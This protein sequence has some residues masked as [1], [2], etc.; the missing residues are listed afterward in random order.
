[1]TSFAP[2]VQLVDLVDFGALSG[3][4][5]A[6]ES[7]GGIAAGGA[8]VRGRASL[9][10][11]G[12]DRLPEVLEILLLGLELVELGVGVAVNPVDGLGDGLVD[13]LLIL[14]ADDGLELLVVEH[15]AQAVGEVLELVLGL[16]LLGDLLVLLL[17]ALGLL[18]ALLD[19]LLGHAALVG[20]DLDGAALAEE[21]IKKRIEK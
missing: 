13:L 21:E 7:G 1:M 3:I 19:L 20:L 9:V 5:A 11:L 6:R 16:H 12:D 8:S 15:V 18:N 17:E 4:V 14:V 10:G 2:I